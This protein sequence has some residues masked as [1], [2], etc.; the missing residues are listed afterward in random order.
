MQIHLPKS[1][2]DALFED[3]QSDKKTAAHP[4]TQPAAA[5]PVAPV[6]TTVSVPVET[7][8]HDDD[9]YQRILAKTDVTSSQAFATLKKYLEPLAS[10]PIDEKTKFGIALKQAPRST[11][12]ARSQRKSMTI[13][14]PMDIATVTIGTNTRRASAK[15]TRRADQCNSAAA[16]SMASKTRSNSSASRMDRTI[17]TDRCTTCSHVS[18]RRS[19]HRYSRARRSRQSATWRQSHISTMRATS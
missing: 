8:S 11:R 18:T 17:H 4:Q 13:R 6:D 15:T 2:S 1:I 14:E 5:A 19:I 12:H 7:I 16:P 10:S 9:A 3:D